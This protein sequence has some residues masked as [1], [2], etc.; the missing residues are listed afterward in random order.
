MRN[1]F[2][3]FGVAGESEC[4]EEG[5]VSSNASEVGM[6]EGAEKRDKIK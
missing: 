3:S 4:W 5:A 1:G 6:D 2:Y